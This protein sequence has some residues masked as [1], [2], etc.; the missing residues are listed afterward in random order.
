MKKNMILF[1][2]CILLVSL[3]SCKEEEV[4]LEQEITFV[5][6]SEGSSYD[7]NLGNETYSLSI[8]SHISETLVKIDSSGNLAPSGAESWEVIDGGKKYIFH[9][10]DNL[11][12]S[13]GVTL[14]AEHF[15]DGFLRIIDPVTKPSNAS[16]LT[17]YFVNA[18][19]YFEGNVSE[20]EIGIRVIDDKTLELELINPTPY[21]LDLLSHQIF[22]PARLEIIKSAGHGWDKNVDIAVSSGAFVLG[23]YVKDEYTTIK[24]NEHYWNSEQV[25]LD[26]VIYKI[27]GDEVDIVSKFNNGEVDCVYEI[28]SSDFRLVPD[29]DIES[30]SRLIPSTAFLI[31]NHESDLLGNDDFRNVLS[32]SI[33]R[34]L[35]VK[36][37]LFGAGVP[38]DYLVPFI[39][40][41]GGES[42]RDYTE[43][44]KELDLN[45]AKDTIS[46]LKE[47]GIYKDEPIRF[48]HIE[49]GVDLV[50]SEEIIRQ[51]REEL[52][53]EIEAKALPWA[54]LYEA[55]LTGDF[56][57]I[58]MGWG[59]DYH[60]PM[61]FLSLFI[62]GSFY[63]PLLRWE[64][65]AYEKA[66]VDSQ[67][68]SDQKEYLKALRDIEDMIL[69]QNHIIPIYHRR[70]LFLMNK[71][72]KGWY[73]RG[74]DFIFDEAYF[75]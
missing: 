64:D 44:V 1:L 46:R 36:N 31:I 30:F 39:Y 28:L 67:Y 15:K 27:R 14:T 54:E 22:S 61:T 74:V 59:A 52:G 29:S 26:R 71:E 20:D 65:P 4:I 43:L 21:L 9:L 69:D 34:E 24:K 60:H 17:P 49:S 47:Q 62:E 75:E 66:I 16:M 57:I 19:E 37:V 18:K 5:I 13:D 55:S 41:I 33:D 73:T 10:R 68:I 42:F 2:I 23:E 51:Y 6:P 58:M 53:I 63:K 45:E 25:K 40:K 3:I 12:W 11:K 38:T 72:L 48:Y 8:M 50:A 35:L 7:N 70:N 32:S 56:D